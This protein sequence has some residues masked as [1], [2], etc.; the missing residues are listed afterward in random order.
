M[1]TFWTRRASHM[2]GESAPSPEL[3][4]STGTDQKAA[5]FDVDRDSLPRAQP[6][7]CILL[8]AHVGQ[9]W[10]GVA[11]CYA[12]LLRSQLPSLVNLAFVETQDGRKSYAQT[13]R[14][15]ARN[16]LVG[17]GHLLRF[18]HALLRTR[19]DVV[20]IATSYGGSL[21]KHG[22]MALIARLFRR[23]VILAPHCSLSRFLPGRESPWRRFVTLV[24]S[25]CD[26]IIVLS[27]EWLA[28]P[29]LVAGC[30][31]VYLPNAI[32]LEPYLILERPRTR[33]K[34]GRVR[35][36]YLGHIGREKGVFEL[37][38]AIRIASAKTTTCFELNIVGETLR[39]GEVD[40]VSEAIVQHDLGDIVHIHPPDFGPGKLRH[41]Q[42]ADVYVLPS[43]HEGM[44]ISIIE[45]MAAGLPIVA[46]HVGGIPDM[47]TPGQTGLLVP[48]KNPLA[49]AEALVQVLEDDQGRLQMGIVARH[50]ASQAHDVRGYVDTL[51]AVYESVAAGKSGSS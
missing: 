22:L 48:P 31:T 2:G 34:G 8:A 11:T 3:D 30:R 50:Y 32:D 42:D 33:P 49:L 26:A 23:K 36:L 46:T 28:L 44:P 51:V 45:A 37:L 20:H 14:P 9:P 10:G 12:D 35:L 5:P 24:L 41:L 43:H 18:V 13:S 1:T 25:Q 4:G 39:A 15:N 17:L 29:H 7:L 19:P 38:D 21:A 40:A 27:R 16:M 6:R 47:V